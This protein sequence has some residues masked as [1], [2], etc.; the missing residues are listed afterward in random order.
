[1]RCRLACPCRASVA[2]ASSRA[3]SSRAQPCTSPTAKMA[4]P[5]TANGAG[6]QAEMST[7]TGIVALMLAVTGRAKLVGGV[8]G[9]RMA[10]KFLFHRPIEVELDLRSL[11]ARPPQPGHQPVIG[12][13]HDIDA[14]RGHLPDPPVVA[15]DLAHLP[16]RRLDIVGKGTGEF[17]LDPLGVVA[18][19]DF[20]D[21]APQL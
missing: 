8:G 12:F 18:R 15:D 3:A 20:D 7:G 13:V 6:F 2:I 5:S 17:Q 16:D 19:R 10:L 11:A 9:R 21:L 14:D 1:M 4:S